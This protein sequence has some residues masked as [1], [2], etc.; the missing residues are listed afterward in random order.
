V[1]Y[2]PVVGLLDQRVLLQNALEDNWKE[3]RHVV[4]WITFW[5][6]FWKSRHYD[7]TVS[8]SE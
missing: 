8:T 5:K 4:Y 1:T 7:F 3:E 6:A 2:T